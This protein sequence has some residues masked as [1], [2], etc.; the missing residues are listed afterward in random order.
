MIRRFGGVISQLWLLR[1]LLFGAPLVVLGPATGHAQD[2]QV[3]DRA[4]LF[5]NPPVF[6]E[7]P[8]DAV[9]GTDNTHADA[10]PNDPDLG[11]QAILKR[12]EHYRAF[13]VSIATP[14]FYTSNVAL[15][16]RG[17]EEDLLFAPSVGVAY[18]PRLTRTL[19][20][21]FA[22]EHQQFFYDR[23]DAL[24]FGSFDARAGLTYQLPQFHDLLLRAAYSYN[25]LTETGSFDEV[26]SNHSL[27]FTAE[28]PFRIGRAMQVSIGTNANVSLH[29][30]P[31][32]PGRHDFDV[33][34]AYSV[35]L[36][37]SLNVSAVARL[38]LRDYTDSGR[39]D[40]SEI[41]ALTATYRFTKWLSASASSTLAWSQSSQSVFDYNVANVGAALSLTYRF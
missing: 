33:F 23:F 17:A 8:A 12:Q 15:V 2:P 4:R 20:A 29:S 36:T 39:T 25:R 10:S 28:L 3:I 11:E 16:R 7:D 22:V 1:A 18:S 24:D 30:E 21:N 19:Y 13:A 35:N 40:V 38:A 14:I 6:A 32:Q 37:R 9:T 34:G 31:E 5:Q 41:V 26:F 27:W